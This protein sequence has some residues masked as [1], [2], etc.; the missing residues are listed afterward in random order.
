MSVEISVDIPFELFGRLS[1][2]IYATKQVIVQGVNWPAARYY[3]AKCGLPPN[4]TPHLTPK[5]HYRGKS[6]N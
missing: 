4:K 6:K 2:K 1:K 3:C 5:C